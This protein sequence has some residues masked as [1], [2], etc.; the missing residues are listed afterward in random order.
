ML[1]YIQN[2]KKIN[3][4]LLFAFT[5]VMIGEY[6]VSKGLLIHYEVIYLLFFIF[7]GCC[8]LLLYPVFKETKVNLLAHSTVQMFI[9]SI[10]LIAILLSGYFFTVEFLP[11]YSFF[12]ADFAALSIFVITCFYISHFNKHP[13]SYYLFVVGA[14]YMIVTA[15]ALIYET[16][17]PNPLLLGLVNLCEILAQFLFV[18]FLAEISFKSNYEELPL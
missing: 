3:W 1:F 10:G 5:S 17:I 18:S 13:K 14:C 6:F 7:F 4:L 8:V 16:V 12:I 15:G 11:N 2:T 9:G